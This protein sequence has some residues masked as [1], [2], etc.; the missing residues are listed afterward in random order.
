M[1]SYFSFQR[2]LGMSRPRVKDIHQLCFK[3]GGLGRDDLRGVD[4]DE[5]FGVQVGAAPIEGQVFL[6]LLGY[7]GSNVRRHFHSTLADTL[8]PEWRATV[9][10]VKGVALPT[11]STGSGIE[12][13]IPPVDL[14]T[15]RRLVSCLR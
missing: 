6:G 1:F 4:D 7:E 14:W 10:D 3:F 12:G 9:L 13:R 15:T 11:A 2:V 5:V 8:T